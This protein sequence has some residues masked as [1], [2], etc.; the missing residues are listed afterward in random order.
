[1]CEPNPPTD[2]AT[3]AASL[4]GVLHARGQEYAPGG[5]IALGYWGIPRGT[6]DVD[7]T[8]FLASERPSDCIWLLQEIGCAVSA[9]AAAESSPVIQTKS[10]DLASRIRSVRHIQLLALSRSRV[11]SEFVDG[12]RNSLPHITG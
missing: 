5:A 1:M 8:L 11:V 4:A 12:V 6:V 10:A 3:V 7:L 9:E 2:A